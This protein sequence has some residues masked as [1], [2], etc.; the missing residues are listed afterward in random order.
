MHDGPVALTL[1]TALGCKL[2]DAGGGAHLVS[3]AGRG[4]VSP[5]P[6]VPRGD[7]VLPP[8]PGR[9]RLIAP[10]PPPSAPGD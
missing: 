10:V 5:A 1:V 6:A 2:P 4:N 9:T 7:G 3:V 8:P